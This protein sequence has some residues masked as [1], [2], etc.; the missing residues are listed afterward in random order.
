[1][2]QT[3]TQSR[4]PRASRGLGKFSLALFLA[5]LPA[6]PTFAAH[7]AAAPT[8][9]PKVEPAPKYDPAIPPAFDEAEK[10][11][12]HFKKPK[13]L[14]VKVWAAEPQLINPVA[15][16]IDDHGRAWVVETDRFRGGG[17]LDI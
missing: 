16:S 14:T 10:A 5:A 9:Q 12:A 15:I 2:P 8:E 13:D 17:V 4:G 7:D 6:T 11:I 1:M 3:F